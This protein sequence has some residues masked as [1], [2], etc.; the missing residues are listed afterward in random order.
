MGRIRL[1]LTMAVMITLVLVVAVP[2]FAYPTD[3]L[4]GQQVSSVAQLYPVDPLRDPG[5]YQGEK[6]SNIA[7]GFQGG[8]C[9]PDVDVCPTP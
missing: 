3:P 5:P 4:R 2:A 8:G 9:G 7:R 6:V 1:V